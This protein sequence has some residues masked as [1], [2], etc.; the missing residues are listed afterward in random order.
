MSTRS[1]IGIIKKGKVKYR[2]NHCDSDL[3]WLGLELATN[4][5]TL[6]KAID[7]YNKDTEV[8]Y[9][10]ETRE[11]TKDEF[12]NITFKDICIEFCYGFDIDKN[13]WFVSS[14]HGENEKIYDLIDLYNDKN[15]LKI[16]CE[17]YIEPYKTKYVKEWMTKGKKLKEKHPKI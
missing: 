9:E 10:D 15:A 12:F 6:E 14:F 8:S 13:R 4:A 5:D 17:M 7:F 2:Y 3:G 11:V 1:Y 16:F